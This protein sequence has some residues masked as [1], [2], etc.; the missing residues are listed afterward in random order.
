[1]DK[2]VIR[3]KLGVCEQN[4]I[5][6][7][8]IMQDCQLFIREGNS[9]QFHYFQSILIRFLCIF[10]ALRLHGVPAADEVEVSIFD[11]HQ[12]PVNKD[13]FPLLV[14]QFKHCN[15]FHFEIRMNR[16]PDFTVLKN[17]IILFPFFIQLTLI[18]IL[19][20]I[21]LFFLAFGK[22]FERQRKRQLRGNPGRRK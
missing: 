21:N 1:M 7:Q 8:E 11:D 13:T 10:I 18:Y 22:V 4:V 16:G 15:N 19:I 9:D 12:A 5:V 6:T 20:I 14:N 2:F 3:A 17:V